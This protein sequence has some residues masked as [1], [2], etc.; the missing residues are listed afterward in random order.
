MSRPTYVLGID[1]GL[2]SMGWAILECSFDY[3][4]SEV[5][6]AVHSA[7][8]WTTQ[9]EA[10]MRQL[11][12]GSDDGRRLDALA[13][14]LFRKIAPM[15]D[16][17]PDIDLFGYELPAGAR[18]ARAAH[19]LG[20]AHGLVRGVLR[21]QSSIAVVEVTARD[22][23][24][25]LTRR[26][27]ATKEEMIE[28]ATA[29]WRALRKLPKGQQEHAADAIGVALAASRTQAGRSIVRRRQNERA[30]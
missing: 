30:A 16:E 27:V 2:A 28:R 6:F 20:M 5:A 21:G 17:G 24:A 11:H 8:V 22:A 18:G 12:V 23:K 9:R 7:G 3:E 10:K 29:A 4:A 14:E 15:D 25:A 1:G 26:P 19:A 13:D